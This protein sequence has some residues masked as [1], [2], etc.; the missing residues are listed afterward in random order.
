V[1]IVAKTGLPPLEAVRKHVPAIKV[2]ML[3][4]CRRHLCGSV[5][6]LIDLDAM[7]VWGQSTLYWVTMSGRS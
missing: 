3:W 2:F 6:D 5:A 7:V 1:G 4:P